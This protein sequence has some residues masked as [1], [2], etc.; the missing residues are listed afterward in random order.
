MRESYILNELDVWEILSNLL[1][2]I[3]GIDDPGLDLEFLVK[4]LRKTT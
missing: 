3:S 2:I 4:A 1:Y